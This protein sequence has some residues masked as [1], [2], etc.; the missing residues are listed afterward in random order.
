ML[1]FLPGSLFAL[2]LGSHWKTL[3]I[4]SELT[5]Q[6]KEITYMDKQR[7]CH[8]EWSFPP[9]QAVRQ[10]DYFSFCL[11]GDPEPS[12]CN[13]ACI[14][15]TWPTLFF[16]ISARTPSPPWNPWTYSP[17]LSQASGPPELFSEFSSF[18]LRFMYHDVFRVTVFSPW[19]LKHF[20]IISKFAFT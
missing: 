8:L 4:M 10:M 18:N 15:C 2:S 13:I 11:G 6:R 1:T 3:A 14:E 16:A 5:G 7:L 19:N 20:I 12:S 17:Y 9:R